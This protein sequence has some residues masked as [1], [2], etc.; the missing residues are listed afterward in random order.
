MSE[1]FSRHVRSARVPPTVARVPGATGGLPAS[2]STGGLLVVPGREGF[3]TAGTLI[4]E[5][6]TRPVVSMRHLIT[7]CPRHILP[8]R[9][10][11][12]RLGFAACLS[13]LLSGAACDS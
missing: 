2:A 12:G 8:F 3:R 5:W 6:R 11:V 7:R 1:R 4:R 13:L 10:A 9:P